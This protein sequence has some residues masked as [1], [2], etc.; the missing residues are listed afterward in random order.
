MVP[1]R[2]DFR[3]YL[4]ENSIYCA[5]H[6]P[7]D[8]LAREERPLAVSLSNNILSLPIDQRYGEKEMAYLANVIDA[9]KGRLKL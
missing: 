4:M 8:G 7:F 5:V 6:W 3:K 9:Y 2:D 1:D